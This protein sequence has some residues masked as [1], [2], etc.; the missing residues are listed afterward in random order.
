MMSLVIGSG[1]SQLAIGRTYGRILHRGLHPLLGV[2][3]IGGE[4]GRLRRILLAE[5]RQ[6]RL[7]IVV[8]GCLPFALVGEGG[9][10]L[11][12]GVKKIRDEALIL[13]PLVTAHRLDGVVVGL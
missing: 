1:L 12:A 3:A 7:Q 5:E 2:G 10:G 13:D 9:N 6:M 4:I 8:A 11:L